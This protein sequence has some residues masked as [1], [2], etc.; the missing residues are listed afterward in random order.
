MFGMYNHNP[1]LPIVYDWGTKQD[2]EFKSAK[3]AILLILKMKK[4][5][6]SKA[7][8]LFHNILDEIEDN[9]PITL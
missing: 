5:S 2:D 4:V 6:L 9:N 1:E 8:I 3:E 7:R